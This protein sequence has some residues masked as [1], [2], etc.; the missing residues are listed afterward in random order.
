MSMNIK[1]F[2][3]FSLKLAWAICNEEDECIRQTRSEGQGTNHVVL[4]CATSTEQ[5][6][7]FSRGDQ[8]HGS[9][10]QMRFRQF[11]IIIHDILLYTNQFQLIHTLNIHIFQILDL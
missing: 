1:R 8:R 2:I 5:T 11:H 3:N 9:M 4:N 10:I 7:A 6:T